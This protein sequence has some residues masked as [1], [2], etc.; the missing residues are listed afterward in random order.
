M[1]TTSA[2]SKYI[3]LRNKI[4]AESN[5]L[6]QRY[7][8]EIVCTKGCDSCCESLTVSPI[9]YYSIKEEIAKLS[10]LPKNKIWNGLTKSCRFIVGGE[11][12]IYQYR[13]IICRTQGLPILYKSLNGNDYE[14]S[15]CNLNFTNRDV[16]TFDMNNSLYM[17]PLNSQ[18]FILNNEFIEENHKGKYKPTDRLKL[19]S[20]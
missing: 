11:C 2:K 5:K 18:L 12:T 19:N 3:T 4:D 1:N 10:N 15:A 13:P 8:L 7:K 16:A 9:E 17:S 14:L 6:E 20:I